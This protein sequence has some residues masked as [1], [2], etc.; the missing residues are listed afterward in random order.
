MKYREGYNDGVQDKAPRYPIEI[1]SL[2]ADQGIA[3]GTVEALAS[4]GPSIPGTSAM[5]ITVGILPGILW[6]VRLLLRISLQKC[7]ETLRQTLFQELLRRSRT[8]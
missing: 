8:L 4:H 6:L 2:H 7:A 1:T 5:A 3:Q